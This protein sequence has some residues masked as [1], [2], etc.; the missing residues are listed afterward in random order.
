MRDPSHLF[1]LRGGKASTDARLFFSVPAVPWTDEDQQQLSRLS[2]SVWEPY[3]EVST[4]IAGFQ[5]TLSVCECSTMGRLRS[6]G[7]F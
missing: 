6:A 4:F 7:P 5:R 2:P 3:G 1:D